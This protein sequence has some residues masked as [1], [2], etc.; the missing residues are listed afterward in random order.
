MTP[1]SALDYVTKH[2]PPGFP[3]SKLIAKMGGVYRLMWNMLIDQGLVKNVQVVVIG[4]GS[5]II[6]VQLLRGVGSV[7]VIDSEDILLPRISFIA[8]LTSGHTLL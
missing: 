7:S 5:Q 4:V 3:H 1:D 6:T 8:D 2:P